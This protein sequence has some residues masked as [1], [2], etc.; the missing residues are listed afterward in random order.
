M[1]I[2][3]F[4]ATQKLPIDL[5]WSVKQREQER[6]SCERGW[7][8][9]TQWHDSG[10]YDK[11]IADFPQRGGANGSIRFYPEIDHAANAGA[12]PLG[13]LITAPRLWMLAMG[14]RP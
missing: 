2:D 6:R 10:S 1:G 11:S 5:Q 7:A 12:Q 3:A 4:S 13:I 8:G 14:S 9:C